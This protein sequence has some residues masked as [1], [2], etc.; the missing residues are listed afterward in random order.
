MKT[1]NPKSVSIVDVA[2]AARVG[3]GTV[4]RVINNQPNVSPATTQSVREAISLLNYRPLPSGSRRGPRLG[5][6]HHRRGARSA[7]VT[8]I[9]LAEYGLDWILQCAPVFASVLHGMQSKT[10]ELG[11]G[12][13]ISQ[14]ADWEQLQAAMQQSPGGCL[15]LGEEPAGPPP[16]GIRPGQMVWVM[17]S[18]RRFG[19]DHVQPD[20]FNLGQLAGQYVLGRGHRHCAYLGAPVSPDYHVSFRG[21]AFQLCIAS[22]GGSVEMLV[23]S[24]LVVSDRRS[25]AANEP[26]IARLLDRMLAVRPRVTALMLQADILA[27]V[28]YSLLR[29]RGVRPGQDV[30]IL[31]CNNEPAYLSHLAPRPVVLDLRA[32]S[33]GKRAVEQ[34]HWR[35]KHPDE[36]AM[37]I[38]VEPGLLEAEAAPVI[39]AVPPARS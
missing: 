23:D 12:L 13:K 16:K 9:V 38:M 3:V 24:G 14:A 35:M 8:L 1:Q 30:E 10:A 18:V 19:G 39:P 4:S 20:H 37:R 34:I 27:P 25:H 29:E 36:P 5:G 22:A 33:I 6:K 28:V 21:A 32:E 31:T 17:G 2:R 26:V 11:C 7:D 15:V